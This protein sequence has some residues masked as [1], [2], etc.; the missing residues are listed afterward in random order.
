M[1]FLTE[2]FCFVGLLGFEPTIII[3]HVCS[4]H[5]DLMSDINM[6]SCGP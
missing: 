3:C 4:S 6:A 5:R 1:G 2:I